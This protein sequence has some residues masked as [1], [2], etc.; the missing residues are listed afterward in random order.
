ML[1]GSPSYEDEIRRFRWEIPERYNIGVDV[2]DKWADVEPER[3]A[4]VHEHRDASVVHVTF[5][6][7]RRCSNQAAN[8]LKARGVARGSRVAILLAQSP[9]TAIAHIAAFKVGAISVPL[10][11]LFGEEALEYRLK[12]SGAS[13][14]VTDAAGVKKIAAIRDR[15][16]DLRS[17]LVTEPV[18][19]SIIE[20]ED[21]DSALDAEPHAYEPV[22]TLAED[23]ATIIYTS[24]TTGKPKGALHAHRVLLG[25]LPGVE[26]SHGGTV[27]RGDIFWTPA[28][29]AWIGGLLDLLLPA[30]HHGATVVSHRFEK[31]NAAAA[32]DLMSRHRVTHV[33]LPPTALKMLRVEKSPRERWDLRLRSIASGGESLGAELLNW[34]KTALNATI[35]EFYGQTECNMVVSSCGNWFEPRPGAIGRAAPGHDVQIVD[36]HGDVV[37]VDQIGNIAIRSPDPVMFLGYWNNP[38]ATAGKF[39]GDFLLTGDLGRM[40][41]DGFIDYV[42]RNDDV[43][44]SAGYRIG[45]GPIEDCLLGHPAVRLVAVVGVPDAERT[46]IVKAYVVLADGFSA[47]DAL[48]RELQDHVRTRL[49]A[50]E[51]PRVIE[52]RESLPMTS[53][54]KLIRRE[55]RNG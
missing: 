24:G 3:I 35:N 33:F 41:A 12:D 20:I 45:P 39:A 14:L 15:L 23:P 9:Q 38:S 43:I 36:D 49:A 13:V 11:S 55:L 47:N 19:D 26:M 5:G 28:D 18:E 16:P 8:C 10:F 52:Y 51:Y 21:F 27:S 42:G 25:H 6:E 7:L 2:C 29:W 22:A 31:F 48:T 4:L 53:T 34:G 40:D 50:H 32:F 17:I 46:E 1:R 37:P 44:T 30:L 54:G